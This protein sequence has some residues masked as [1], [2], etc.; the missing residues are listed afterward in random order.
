[1]LYRHE[2]YKVLT[3]SGDAPHARLGRW[4]N[5]PFFFGQKI[6]LSNIFVYSGGCDLLILFD[7]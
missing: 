5:L 3:S 7:A 4:R 1:M 6:S 2:N